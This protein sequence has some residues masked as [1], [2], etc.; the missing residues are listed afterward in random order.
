MNLRPACLVRVA[1]AAAL[2]AVGVTARE[3]VAQ[4]TDA[5]A[6]RVVEAANP[7]ADVRGASDY[8]RAVCGA[9]FRKAVDVALRRHRGETVKGGHV[10]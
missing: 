7:L 2:L 5:A 9:L 3:A 6:E 4:G 1:S 10:R 8:K